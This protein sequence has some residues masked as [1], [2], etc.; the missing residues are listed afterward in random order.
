MSEKYDS[1][2]SELTLDLL[3]HPKKISEVPITCVFVHPT[4]TPAKS[5][6]L[7]V[8]W[9]LTN[10]CRDATRHAELVA[11][12]RYTTGGACSDDVAIFEG[13]GVGKGKGK[14]DEHED[15]DEEED[16]EDRAMMK[17]RGKAEDLK[18]STCYVTIEPCIQCAFALRKIGVKRVV[19][20]AR[21]ERFGGC[22]SLIDCS[23]AEFCKDGRGGYEVDFVEDSNAVDVLR[24][25]YGR[26]NMSAPESKR[27]KK[28]EREG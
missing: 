12:D 22:G 10:A 8:G 13:A 15:E 20:G 28:G 1:F 7:C 21:N 2:Y 9:N 23:R 4:E 6:V 3:R 19:F 11:V 17:R 5:D 24:G 18:G 14:E 16:E 25:F 26:E 27:R